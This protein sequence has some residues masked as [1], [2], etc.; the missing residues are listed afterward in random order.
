MGIINLALWAIGVALVAVGYTRV[1][2]PWRRYRSL[3][4]Q[5][6][7][8]RRYDSW[9]GGVRGNLGERTGAQVMLEELRR[10]TRIWAGVVITGFILVVLGF[11]LR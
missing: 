3:L 8:Q 10:Q 1:R 4:D 6:A 7:N 11:F 5:Q 9:R 2:G